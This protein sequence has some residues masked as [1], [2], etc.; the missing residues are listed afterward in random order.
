MAELPFRLY[1]NETTQA[2][3]DELR[4]NFPDL[5]NV[6]TDTSI[7]R[8]AAREAKPVSQVASTLF[9]LGIQHV[10]TDFAALDPEDT[11]EYMQSCAPSGYQV[12]RTRFSDQAL[13]Y[14]PPSGEQ[15]REFDGVH[16]VELRHDA[17]PHLVITEAKR[18]EKRHAVVEAMQ[19]AV[20]PERI[21]R[22]IELTGQHERTTYQVIYTY[23]GTEITNPTLDTA[24]VQYG[25]SFVAAGITNT[26]L[27]D[28]AASLLP[29]YTH[30]KT[31]R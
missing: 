28:I 10:M 12:E 4:Y 7:A 15:E 14:K 16:V 2:I 11:I 6:I 22:M 17:P 3:A 30:P 20:K 8:N 13:Y 19:L 31:W 24:A 25:V 27:L 26:E 9:E 29:R 18:A 1:T 5:R 21:A 23:D